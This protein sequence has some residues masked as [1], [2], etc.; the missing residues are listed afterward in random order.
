[1]QRIFQKLRANPIKYL[2]HIFQKYTIA[3]LKY[4]Q[5]DDY[6]ASRYWDDRFKRQGSTLVAVGDEGLSLIENQKM[7]SEAKDVFEK[8]LIRENIS[9]RNKKILEIGTGNGFFT[10]IVY[11]SRPCNYQ[12][13]DITDALFADL[14]TRF[15]EFQFGKK[16]ITTELIKETYDI[17]LFIDVIE[18][19]VNEEKMIF[20]IKN[21]QKAL[22]PGGS[23]IFAP[24]MKEPQKEHFYLRLWTYDEIAPHLKPLMTDSLMP[25]RY[26]HIAVIRKNVSDN[27]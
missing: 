3:I 10:K 4:K 17:V 6:N 24:F 1:M 22:K 2:L 16:D 25:F 11:E 5:K 27:E 14:Q 12:G 7:Y 18:H 8:L 20:A 21:I 19:I 15:P 13:I 9:F 26:G 23:L